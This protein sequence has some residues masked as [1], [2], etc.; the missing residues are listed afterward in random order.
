MINSSSSKDEVAA[1]LPPNKVSEIFDTNPKQN[2]TVVRRT[3]VYISVILGLVVLIIVPLV[4]F[5]AWI[6]L[7]ATANH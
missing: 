6:L 4:L 7:Y 1:A 3:Q 5:V 2:S